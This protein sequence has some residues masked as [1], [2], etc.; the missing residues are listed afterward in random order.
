MSFDFR[1]VSTSSPGVTRFAPL[2]PTSLE[3]V[4]LIDAADFFVFITLRQT[5]GEPFLSSAFLISLFCCLLV[6]ALECL[7]N[8]LNKRLCFI[9]RASIFHEHR[10]SIHIS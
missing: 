3:F 2:L 6:F 1:F 10:P 8:L 9:A 4:Y 7:K 5:W